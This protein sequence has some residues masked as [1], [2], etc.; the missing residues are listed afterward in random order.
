[1]QIKFVDPKEI[2]G[3]SQKIFD[4]FYIGIAQTL[5][6][7]GYGLKLNFKS[8]QES[9]KSSFYSYKLREKI[10]LMN[11]SLTYWNYFFYKLTLSKKSVNSITY[12]SFLIVSL[13]QNFTSFSKTADNFSFL[14]QSLLVQLGLKFQTKNNSTPLI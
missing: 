8:L 9:W 3:W 2:E 14:D 13:D 10:K 1:M 12:N 6:K 5:E 11:I 7:R 4:V